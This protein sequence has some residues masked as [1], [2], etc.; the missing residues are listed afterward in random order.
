MKAVVLHRVGFLKYFCPKQGQD[1]K[2]SVAPIYPN[3][4]QVPP[5]PP[6][7]T[8]VLIYWVYPKTMAYFAALGAQ[9]NMTYVLHDIYFGK[10]N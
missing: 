2:P 10:R 1:F 8:C 6:P 3:M 7:G 4:G 9:I 5:P